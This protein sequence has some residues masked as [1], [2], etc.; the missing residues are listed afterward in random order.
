MLEWK[1]DQNPTVIFE[2]SFSETYNDLLIDGMARLV[3]VFGLH[4]DKTET[5]KHCQTASWY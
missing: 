1:L 5:R 3:V 2:A 4:E